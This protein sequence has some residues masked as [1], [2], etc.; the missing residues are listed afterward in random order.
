MA[1]AF[2]SLKP[3]EQKEILQTA[4]AQ[5]G[6]QAAVLEK[7]IWVCWVFWHKMEESNPNKCSRCGRLIFSIF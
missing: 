3:L 6:R 2:L 7:D 1:D 5:L 4:T